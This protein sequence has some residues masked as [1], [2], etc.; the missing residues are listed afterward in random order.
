MIFDRGSRGRPERIDSGIEAID[1]QVEQ[2]ETSWS[3]PVQQPRR[4]RGG[5]GLTVDRFRE[6]IVTDPSDVFAAGPWRGR[7]LA[8]LERVYEDL[9]HAV[10]ALAP[11][12]RLT[13]APDRRVQAHAR[14]GARFLPA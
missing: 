14:P 8:M 12:R 4:D 5:D 10:A 1:G 2:L 6:I 9:E 3:H 7:F 13:A 11:R